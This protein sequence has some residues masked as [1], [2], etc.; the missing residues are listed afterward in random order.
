MNTSDQ[1]TDS[2]AVATDGHRLVRLFHAGLKPESELDIIVPAKALNLVTKSFA[3][4]EQITLRFSPS[5]VQFQSGETNLLS[6]LIDEAN[7][8]PKAE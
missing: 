3:D 6:R 4:S 1:A 8:G 5:H 7:A 2:R